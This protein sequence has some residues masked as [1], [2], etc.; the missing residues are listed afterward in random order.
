MSQKRRIV[1]LA[2]LVSLTSMLFGSFGCTA[3]V[4]SE[5][6]HQARV[7]RREERR[8]ERHEI[9]HEERERAREDGY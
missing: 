7:E 1:S 4:R 6:P 2:Y 8:E 3:E 9:R 5:T